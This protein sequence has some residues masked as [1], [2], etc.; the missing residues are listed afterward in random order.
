[1][2]V[3]LPSCFGDALTRGDCGV[4]EPV[5][6]MNRI[7]DSVPVLEER[8]R[9]DIERLYQ[10]MDL[11]IGHSSCFSLVAHL[12]FI[13][14]QDTPSGS[15]ERRVWATLAPE[16]KPAHG[17][18]RR[19]LNAGADLCFPPPGCAKCPARSRSAGPL[20]TRNS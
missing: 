13:G 14:Q 20:N 12:V 5:C 19:S 1:M 3:A 6:R 17:T 9:H 16:A 15:C 2:I 10:G 11:H 8:E 7:G 18:V 4:L